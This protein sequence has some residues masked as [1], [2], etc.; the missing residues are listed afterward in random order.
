MIIYTSH[1]ARHPCRQAPWDWETE[2]QG[3]RSRSRLLRLGHQDVA[4]AHHAAVL[5][6]AAVV[7]DDGQHLAIAH[8]DGPWLRVARR[9]AH[10]VVR[11]VP[12][13]RSCAVGWKRFA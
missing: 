2:A 5:A 3:W 4:Q 9:H 7:G 8:L 6:L 13:L 10:Y 12:C 11:L 1:V